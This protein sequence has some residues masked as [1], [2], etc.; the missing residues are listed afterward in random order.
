M[1]MEVVNAAVWHRGMVGRC[2]FWGEEQ[3]GGDMDQPPATGRQ[4][5]VNTRGPRN[6]WPSCQILYWNPP[7]APP[8]DVLSPLHIFPESSY[9]KG[10]K[11]ETV[12][13]LGGIVVSVS[14]WWGLTVFLLPKTTELAVFLLF[15]ESTERSQ[16]TLLSITRCANV[17]VRVCAPRW[18]LLPVTD[19]QD[20]VPLR[21][22]LFVNVQFE[23]SKRRNDRQDWSP[24]H[25]RQF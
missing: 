20:D 10:Q 7:E 5:G 16:W 1:Y 19:E 15:S 13:S 6:R 23:A 17:Q 25:W 3:L 22:F 14:V 9:P 11:K 21:H 4:D 2:S 12:S 24:Q 8:P 18:Q